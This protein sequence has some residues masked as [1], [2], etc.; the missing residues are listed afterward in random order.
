MFV[1][2]TTG[3]IFSTTSNSPLTKRKSNNWSALGA[4]SMTKNHKWLSTTGV[5]AAESVGRPADGALSNGISARRDVGLLGEG[6]LHVRLP[7]DISMGVNYRY[8]AGTAGVCDRPDYRRAAVGHGDPP[9]RRVRHAAQ[10][11]PQRAGLQSAKNFRCGGS[12]RLAATVE[13]FNLT[14]SDAATSVNYQYRRG[15][16]V[17]RVRFRQ[18][19]DSADDR[20]RRSGIQV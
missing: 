3:R 12:K 18:H 19:G 10:S 16:H 8:L 17:A 4:L 20:T 5:F 13:L 6:A 14:N 15:Q 2:R 1:N 7:R 9:A 11:R